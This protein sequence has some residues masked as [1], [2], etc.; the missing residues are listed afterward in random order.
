[1]VIP[2]QMW[3]QK[4]HIW[5]TI[6][7]Y[8]QPNVGTKQEDL[9]EYDQLS[10]DQT[11]VSK[12]GYSDRTPLIGLNRAVLYSLKGGRMTMVGT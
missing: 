12:A 1:M 5:L 4:T 9:A 11:R 6:N 3:I 10:D 7:Y 8:T 2:S